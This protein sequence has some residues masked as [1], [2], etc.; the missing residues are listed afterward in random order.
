MEPH[1]VEGLPNELEHMT[2]C[3]EAATRRVWILPN[4]TDPTTR[5][6]D[7]MGGRTLPQGEYHLCVT[8]WD[9]SC[10]VFVRQVSETEGNSGERF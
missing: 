7:V 1:T 8:L 6:L 5:F 3:F 10:R 9:D 4:P 2:L